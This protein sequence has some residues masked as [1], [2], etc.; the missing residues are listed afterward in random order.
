M[1]AYEKILATLD[2]G[3]GSEVVYERATELAKIYSTKLL[4][5]HVVEYVPVDLGSDFMLPGPLEIEES[6]VARAR[7]NLADKVK[8][9]DDIDVVSNV[10]IGVTKL[11]IIRYADDNQV[12]LIVI[13]RHSRQGIFKLLG[14][15]ANAVL[16]HAHCDVLAVN[17]AE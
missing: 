12:D 13:G 2:F 3:S 6:L 10:E 17:I 11:E 14:S 15:T 8:A 16:H 5:L 1:A 4:L 9:L 7:E